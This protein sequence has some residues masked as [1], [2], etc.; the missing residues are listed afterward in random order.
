LAAGNYLVRL[1][2]TTADRVFVVRT[3]DAAVA[4]TPVAI[5]GFYSGTTSSGG[6]F[7]FNVR[8]DGTA[9]FL[10][11]GD[12]GHYA[13]NFT[14]ASWGAFSV[15]DRTGA[16]VTGQITVAGNVTGTIGTATF[17]GA[18]ASAGA[19]D[20]TR[21]GVYAGWILDAGIRAEAVVA[22]GRI[23]L[24]IE[25]AG[26]ATSAS[27]P[28]DASGAF[29][30]APQ[31]GV[32]FA[33]TIANELVQADVALPSHA[34]RK[35]VLLREGF[36][37]T[38]RL[39]NL[40]M[41]CRAAQGDDLLIAGFVVEGSMP[42]PVLVRGVG[43]G[44]EKFSMNAPLQFPRLT[45]R[46]GQT[47]LAQNDG[48]DLD[49]NSASIATVGTRTSAFVLASGS[50]DDAL[51]V[52]LSRGIY[53][54]EIVGSDGGS[55]VALAEIYDARETANTTNLVNLSARGPVGTGDDI[56]IGG[57]VIGG[58][59]P[60]LVL[61]RAAGPALTRFD[62][63]NTLAQPVLKVF[64]GTTVIATGAAWGLGDAPANVAAATERVSAFSF[65]TGS[66]DAAMLL[67]LPPGAY[68]AQVSG[69]GG[70][71][72]IALIEVYQV[73]DF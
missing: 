24:V 35:V 18:R 48:W 61:A 53:T 28:F 5:E 33:G 30:L 1:D 63:S 31:S 52:P 11:G 17:A 57:F 41:R 49:G 2:L 3:I 25:E 27:G 68:T 56:M 73:P 55:G 39:L 50:H 21:D 36:A 32:S 22:S 4:T 13:R 34:S 65:P 71:T 26:A 43:P 20:A 66:A 40:S 8:A 29:S 72:G 14:V 46:S 7:A 19:A 64:R 60:M 38:R 15:T 62:V 10:A 45:L 44:L 47:V 37:P 42:L 58:D 51:L 9:T 67:F 6:T 23:A 69:A 12:R 70:A 59:A 16:V 54:A